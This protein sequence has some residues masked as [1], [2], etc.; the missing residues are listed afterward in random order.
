M[1]N[2]GYYIVNKF[3]NEQ[4]IVGFKV[5]FPNGYG[6]SV[7]FGG[8]SSSDEIKIKKNGSSEEYFSSTAEIAVLNPNH[9]LIPFEE[10]SPVRENVRTEK[11]LQI[12][13]WA[14]NR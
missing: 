7:I 8:D 4:K 12:L 1:D 11:L 10:N 2:S 3:D 6:V 14:M 5:F 13:S 9:E